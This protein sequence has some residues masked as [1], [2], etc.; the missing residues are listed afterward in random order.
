MDE[1]FISTVYIYSQFPFAWYSFSGKYS[2]MIR[3]RYVMHF[4]G[5]SLTKAITVSKR[6]FRSA[7]FHIELELEP[8]IL[9]IVLCHLNPEAPRI[10]TVQKKKK[11]TTDRRLKL[12]VSRIRSKCSH[13]WTMRW[14]WVMAVSRVSRERTDFHDVRRSSGGQAPSSY[15]HPHTHKIHCQS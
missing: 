6:S 8:Y 5:I 1:G 10:M 11:N 9:K 3:N 7:M 15:S 4:R 14:K 2:L 13:D 12:E